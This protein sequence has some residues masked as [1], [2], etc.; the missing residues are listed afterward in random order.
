MAVNYRVMLAD[1]IELVYRDAACFSSLFNRDERKS[2]QKVVYAVR[3]DMKSDKALAYLACLQEPEMPFVWHQTPEAI[4]EDG[5]VIHG[6][7]L[8]DIA[9]GAMTAVRYLE[10]S[11]GMINN[12]F[13][14]QDAFPHET[15]W[16]LL[17]LA[18]RLALGNRLGRW[19]GD[20]HTLIR[21][22]WPAPGEFIDRNEVFK[23]ARGKKVNTHAGSEI[24][25]CYTGGS[26]PSG[27]S[28]E[29]CY[30]VA[31]VGEA[32]QIFKGVKKYERV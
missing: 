26:N 9:Y 4:L 25:L 5:L 23:R 18:H 20:G 24:T 10:E 8:R 16:N 13:A 30:S 22:Y 31:E 1:G 21:R 3:T 17:Q 27:Y 14:M 29:R 32:L 2:I 15:S 28:W 7:D 19:F 11:E 6:D 12:F